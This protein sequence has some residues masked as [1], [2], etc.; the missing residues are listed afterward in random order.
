M[1]EPSDYTPRIRFGEG[2]FARSPRGVLG[3]LL[4]APVTSCVSVVHLL[5]HGHI[6]GGVVALIFLVIALLQ[7][8]I[9]VPRALEAA[10]RETRQRS[11]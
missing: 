10:R 8:A 5:A 6:F 11:R 7:A 1:A 9:Y 2:G 4:V 3:E